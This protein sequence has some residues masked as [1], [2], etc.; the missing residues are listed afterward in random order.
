MSDNKEK[1]AIEMSTYEKDDAAKQLP[2]CILLPKIDMKIGMNAN[3]EDAAAEDEREMLEKTEMNTS[4]AED[5]EKSDKEWFELPA[6]K[7][8]AEPDEVSLN[9]KLQLLT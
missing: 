8:E 9:E 1:P 2:L 4:P 6:A 5:S 7:P 3:K